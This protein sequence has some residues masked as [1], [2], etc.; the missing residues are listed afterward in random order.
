MKFTNKNRAGIVGNST[1]AAG[2]TCD[3]CDVRFWTHH[4]RCQSPQHVGGRYVVQ[5]VY[6][7]PW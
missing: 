5:D 7:D 1:N 3:G 2:G 6:E 4:Q